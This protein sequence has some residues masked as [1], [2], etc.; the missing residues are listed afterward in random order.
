MSKFNNKQKAALIDAWDELKKVEKAKNINADNVL[1]MR[2][3]FDDKLNWD[4]K[5]MDLN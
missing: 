2:Q 4:G 1:D 5:A 3:K